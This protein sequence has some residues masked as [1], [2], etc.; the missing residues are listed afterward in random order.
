VTPPSVLVEGS[1]LTALSELADDRIS[2]A[3]ECYVDLLGR[4]ERHEIR[5]RARADHL[6]ATPRELRRTL[7]A[8]IEPVHIAAQFRRAAARLEMPFEFDPDM[9]LTLVVMR[10]ERINSIATLDRRFD[11]VKF[12]VIA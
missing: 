2:A 6:A 8:P 3:A 12:A 9:A 11:A 7:F 1:L 4:Y 5:I 10:R